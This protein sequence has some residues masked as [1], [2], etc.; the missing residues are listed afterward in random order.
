MTETH[1]DKL[2]ALLARPNHR[3]I[4]VHGANGSAEIA[5]EF[6]G[7]GDTDQKVPAADVKIGTDYRLLCH[8]IE[9]KPVLSKLST[10]SEFGGKNW[11]AGRTFS[12][13]VRS[14]ES[15]G[16]TLP[17]MMA[18]PIGR[19]GCLVCEFSGHTEI[20]AI[21]GGTVRNSVRLTAKSSKFG[22]SGERSDCVRLRRSGGHTRE[23][24]QSNCAAAI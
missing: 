24:V 6:P 20:G 9:G 23:L 4:P 21:R 19:S 12:G 17:Q 8:A 11:T 15:V 22:Y 1:P 16:K 14:D 3:T 5:L 7:R 10:G 13:R 18:V 2:R